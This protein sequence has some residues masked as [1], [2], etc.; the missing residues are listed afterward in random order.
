MKIFTVRNISMTLIKYWVGKKNPKNESQVLVTQRNFP[1]CL[2]D[3]D[4]YDATIWQRTH[5]ERQIDRQTDC[6]SATILKDT[7]VNARQ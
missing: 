5:A 6:Y 7:Q 4:Q 2:R 3:Q 1:H